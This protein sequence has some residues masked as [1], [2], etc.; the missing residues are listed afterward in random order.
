MCP[1]MPRHGGGVKSPALIRCAASPTHATQA[2][3]ATPHVC[4]HMLTIL[5]ARAVQ[6]PVADQ[7][8][9]SSRGR[10]PCC[11]RPCLRRRPRSR[12]RGHRPCAVC[13][14]PCA[15]CRVPWPWAVGRKPWAAGRGLW[16][17]G[18]GPWAVDR[19]PCAV[20]RAPC[21]VCRAPCTCDPVCCL[22]AKGSVRRPRSGWGATPVYRMRGC[23]PPNA[24]MDTSYS[25]LRAILRG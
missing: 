9:W 12:P 16:A 5:F 10:R 8:A 11:L 25:G 19:G 22:L 3:P 1:A 2:N 14:V 21:A 24:P 7:T 17:V 13:R 23:S 4:A 15:L 18:R 20:R 6:A